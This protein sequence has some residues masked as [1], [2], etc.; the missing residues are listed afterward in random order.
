[1]AVNG[2]YS[3]QDFHD[4][5]TAIL[6]LL[7]TYQHDKHDMQDRRQVITMREDLSVLN[8]QLSDIAADILS[9]ALEAS[10]V[11]DEFKEQQTEDLLLE[12]KTATKKVSYAEDTAKRRAKL[13]S[14]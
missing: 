10:R 9:D 3:E 2:F 13:A 7:A 8:V 6:G 1:M 14:Q 12:F 11:R 4:I 5:R